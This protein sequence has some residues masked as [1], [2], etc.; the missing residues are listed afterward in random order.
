MTPTDF[1]LRHDIEAELDWDT[2]LDSRQ[3][4]VAV[5]DGIVTLSGYVS[6]YP[7][8]RAAEEAAQ[9]LAGVRAV[10]NDIQVIPPESQCLPDAQ[11]AD[12]AWLA[13]RSNVSVPAEQ[14][15]LVVHEG[16]VRLQG[17]VVLWAQRQAAESALIHLPGVRGISNDI[18]VNSRASAEDIKHLIEQAIR[19]R[20]Q[21]ATRNIVVRSSEHTV[22]L[23]GEVH[24]WDEREQAEAAARH[25]PGVA[26]VIDRL[27]VRP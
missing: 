21:L 7:Q 22:T 9:R 24:S 18:V 25:A 12:A 8:S 23:E 13:L 17:E 10:A 27:E 14:L 1:E 3:I 11:I 6:T 5:K 19:R 20:S 16:W 15:Q 26:H 4:G 2:R